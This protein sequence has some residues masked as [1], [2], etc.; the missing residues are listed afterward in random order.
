MKLSKAMATFLENQGSP[1]TARAYSCG[2]RRFFA[3]SA[4]TKVKDLDHEQA[5][6]FALALKGEG[7][8]PRTISSYLTALVQFVYWLKKKKMANVSAENLHELREEVKD[9]NK[10]N[11]TK[12]LPR[13]PTPLQSRNFLYS[14]QYH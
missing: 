7:L 6:A 10:K 13:L 5:N 11:K 9:W 3:W 12:K 1:N 4:I 14:P 8:S 2:L